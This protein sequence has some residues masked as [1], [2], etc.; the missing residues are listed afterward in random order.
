MDAILVR[1]RLYLVRH[2]QTEWNANGRA[3]GHSDVELDSTGELQAKAVASALS[4]VPIDH[5]YA[6][7]LKRCMQT[8]SPLAEQMGL[9]IK[10]REDLRER[11][12]GELEGA[13]Y[14]DIRAFFTAESR[15]QGLEDYDIRP[16][17]GESLR[18]VWNRLDKFQREVERSQGNI[19]IFGHGG[20]LGVLLAK[21]I[22][23]AVATSKSFRFE[24]GAITEL[25][26]RPDGF[27]QLVRYA[28]TTHLA[29]LREELAR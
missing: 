13:H 4:V 20:A 1:M 8:G 29:E 24:N 22:R 21:L 7:D 15:V 16:D 9:E 17:N 14:T 3:Q 12:F 5:I 18:D 28:D 25:I 23:S 19:A 2:G 6:S 26:Y 10:A 27:W 11:T